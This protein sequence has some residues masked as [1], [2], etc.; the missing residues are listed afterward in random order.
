MNGVFFNWDEIGWT[1]TDALSARKVVTL[2]N[3]MFVL[4]R[5]RK[6]ADAP[7]HSHPHEQLSTMLSGRIIAHIGDEQLELGPMQ[8][9]R[10]PANVP[11]KVTVLEDALI[12]DAFSP[13]RREFLT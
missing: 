12:L 5:L 6:G 1:E 2:E 7:P 4:F 8:G 11:H 3:V 10:V 13:I 9:Y